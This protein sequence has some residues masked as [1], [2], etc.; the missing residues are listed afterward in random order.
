M[1]RHESDREDLW[2]EAVALTCRIEYQLPDDERPVLIGYRDNGWCS[3][4]VGQDFM[5]QF[6]PAGG[7]RRAFHEGML[8][9]TQGTA[10]CRLRRSRTETSTELLRSDLSDSELGEFR[11]FVHQTVRRLLD[12]ITSGTAAPQRCVPQDGKMLAE[13]I[14]ATINQVLEVTEFLAPAIVKRR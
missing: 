10:L 2:A 12:A 9:R 14:A 13:R 3:I 5:L 4:Y 6:T 8:Y 1:A 11:Q 7:L